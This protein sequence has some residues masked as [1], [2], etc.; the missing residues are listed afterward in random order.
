MSPVEGT[1]LSQHAKALLRL[2]AHGATAEIEADGGR[3]QLRLYNRDQRELLGVPEFQAVWRELIAAGYAEHSEIRS[4][5]AR[6]CVS[7]RGFRVARP[8]GGWMD[9]ET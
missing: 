1:A 2:L 6:L 4:Q 9:A 5:R 8:H 3:T 7:E